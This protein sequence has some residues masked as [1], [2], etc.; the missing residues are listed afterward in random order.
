LRRRR[1]QPERRRIEVLEVRYEAGKFGRG[2]KDRPKSPA[3]IRVVPM[4][5]AVRKAILR[6][7][8][9]GGDPEDLVFAGPGGNR[10]AKRGA[11]PPLRP[12]TTATP[13]RPRSLPG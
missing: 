11:R 10:W 1:V 3:S 13:T 4:A 5:E 6:Q 9:P 8:P 12:T 2:F 7:L